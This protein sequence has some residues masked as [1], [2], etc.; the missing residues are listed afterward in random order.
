M[1]RHFTLCIGVILRE[2]E[3]YAY[4]HFLKWGTVPPLLS[5][6]TGHLLSWNC[7]EMH[8]Q[9]RFHPGPR[10]GSLQHSTRPF[11]SIKGPTS[12]GEGRGEVVP[13]LF[14]EKLHP[15]WGGTL[16]LWVVHK[17]TPIL[18]GRPPK[19]TAN[20][21]RCL[22]TPLHMVMSNYSAWGFASSKD[23]ENRRHF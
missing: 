4:P 21:Q 3:G 8:G 10:S 18:S 12:K 20:F 22:W 6:T 11:S 14:G 13:P 19:S 15:L 7:A 16:S 17:K 23:I 9:P 5:A 2:F 1:W